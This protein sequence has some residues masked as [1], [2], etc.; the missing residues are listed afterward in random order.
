M[1]LIRY[2]FFFQ[3][4]DG[5]TSVP[6]CL[7]ATCVDKVNILELLISLHGILTIFALKSFV[8]NMIRERCITLQYSLARETNAEHSILLRSLVNKYRT[9][10]LEERVANQDRAAAMSTSVELQIR[11]ISRASS[12]VVPST[13]PVQYAEMD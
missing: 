2:Y 7:F 10:Q 8:F 5:A 6:L 4:N 1:I 11:P 12:A 3:W 9:L 13:G